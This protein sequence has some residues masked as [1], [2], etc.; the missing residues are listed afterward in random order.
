MEHLHDKGIPCPGVI[1]AK[2]GL[3]IL[4][5]QGKPAL[6]TTFLEGRWPRQIEDYQVSVVGKVLAHMHIAGE[7]FPQR[8]GNVMSLPAWKSLIEACGD[9]ADT[10][11]EGL[12]AMLQDELDYLE[13]N[14]PYD[15][16]SGAVHAD[17]FPDNVFFRQKRLT[18]IIDFYFSCTDFFAYDLMLTLNAWCFEEEGLNIKKSTALINAYE[19]ERPLTALEQE[20]LPLFG[21][22]AA[23]R[24][25]ATRL[26][27]WLHPVENAVVK[28]KD[29]LE[30]VQI[31]SFYRTRS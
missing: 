15:L 30:Y 24:I 28:P 10:V 1:P 31:L 27:D 8:R 11:H 25:V 5:F 13:K 18:G 2:S 14:W 16:P 23:L 22:A 17:L 6:I 19:K 29:P 9:K 7:K 26:Y 4:D 20:S 12:S 3:K 21:R